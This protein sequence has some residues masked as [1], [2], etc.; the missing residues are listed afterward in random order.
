MV[1]NL[2][3]FEKGE[4]K[5]KFK[6]NL[7]K[8]YFE[9]SDDI[10]DID[11]V[12]S[13]S[14]KKYFKSLQ[15]E[16]QKCY[17]IAELARSKNFD[18]DS[19]VEISIAKN[20]AERVVGLI[21]VVAPQIKGS[22]VV[23]R[24]IELE[25]EYGPLDWRVALKIAEEVAKERFC[26]FKDKK[27]AIEIGIRTGFA[28][29]TV[30]VVSSPLD[31]FIGIDIKQRRDGR[32]EFFCVKYAGPIRNA[33]GTNAALSVLIADYVRKKMGYDVFD[34]DEKEMKRTFT[35]LQDYHERITNLQYNPHEEEIEFLMKHIP[36]EVGG[37]PSEKIEV[38]N[39]KDLPRIETNL[40]RSGF[41]LVMSSCVPL[42]APKLWAKL[43]KWGNDFDMGQWN[44][45]EKYIKLQKELKSKKS[46]KKTSSETST[47]KPKI[48]PDY[49]FV[50]DIVA[51]RP[52]ISHPMQKGGF[53]LRYGRSRTSGYS[54]QSINPATMAVLDNFIAI[55]T[56][57]KVERPGKGAAFTPCE[58][59]E[60]PLVRLKDG[61]VLKLNDYDSAKKYVKEVDKIIFLGDV[62]INYG[63]FFDRAHILVPCG[64]N[65]EW[66]ALEL[67]KAIPEKEL[68]IQSLSART[69][70]KPEIIQDIV[71]NY[72]YSSKYPCI[73]FYNFSKVLDIP[74]H[75]AYTFHFNDV[76][77]DDF[78]KL[79]QWLKFS[80][81]VMKESKYNNYFIDDSILN[82]Q[83]SFKIVLPFKG[84]ENEKLLL[85]NIGVPHEL[86]N[87]EYVVINRDYSLALYAS[88]GLKLVDSESNSK[89]GLYEDKI[90]E[91]DKDYLFEISENLKGNT[92]V[93]DFINSI[94]KIRIRDKS[95]TYIGG[96][97]GRPEKAKMRK[98]QGSPHGLFPVG[99]QGGRMRSLNSA[100]ESGIVKADFSQFY[101][102][103]CKTYTPYRVC[104]KCSKPTNHI[105]LVNNCDVKTIFD[106]VK[107]K[108]N[109]N[110]NKMVKGVRG[111]VN[112]EHI[113][114]F[115]AKSILRA[116]H[117]VHVN[118]DGTVRYD[119][120]EMTCT[121]FK[122]KEI[123]VSIDRL[124]QLGY[125]LDIFGNDLV[126]DN[127][128]LELKPQD[129]ILPSCPDAPEEPADVVLIKITKYIDELLEKVYGI[130]S[131]YNVNKAED[132]VGHLIIGLAPHTSA[133]M[134]GRIIGFSKTQTFLAHPYYHAAERRDTDGDEI[135]FLLLLDG[136]LNFSRKFLT[137]NRGS[138]MDAPLVLSTILRPAEVDDMAFNV[139]VVA[140]YPLEL[141]EAAQQYKAP[142]EI[143]I[144]IIKKLLDSEDQYENMMFTHDTDNFNKGVLCSVYKTLPSMQE[145]LDGQL[146]LARKIRAVDEAD[147]ARLV[148]EKH[149]LKDL[150]GNLRKFSMQKFR[151]VNCNESYRRPPIKGCCLKCNGKIIFTIS[152]G[153]IVKYLQ[154]SLNIADNFAISPYLKQTLELLKLRIEDVFGKEQEKQVGLSTFF[155]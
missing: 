24:I 98:M 76:S 128:V 118:K 13:D 136:F 72:L 78:L 114:E 100:I 64:Y 137:D 155:S 58:T 10:S 63:D 50:S 107:Q 138:T 7:T 131:Y 117:D 73:V 20:M 143:D 99:E 88:L 27:E 97:M 69:N 119:A 92:N 144:K 53:R 142:Y 66:Y 18:P 85:E 147:V 149:F 57:L 62:L 46:A 135:G 133:G 42:K 8:I 108:F 33:G 79:I 16:T 35:E 154:P 141:Y 34:P 106:S 36:V 37:E 74:L 3:Q 71:D 65:E 47:E 43:S 54:A 96:R 129:I 94:S 26:K 109:I 22:G 49:T 146:N 59:I 5:D 150:K 113:P 83:Y 151:C 111:T 89:F 31:G 126:D 130:E 75:P 115:L 87:N 68:S 103:D 91:I 56:Q 52:V 51:G 30:G 112:K 21:S 127:Q 11:V 28:Y 148:I 38:S 120:S 4:D 19:V 77:K 39:Y 12:A 84:Y 29:S 32:G 139:D 70:I 2:N 17:K 134:V 80:E 145:K 105:G 122:P 116:I 9:Y 44:F 124:K 95:G 23:E 152:E 60:G 82:T 123:A 48:L 102:E 41:C 81:I 45:L 86:I 104:L 55:G 6:N 14:I 67:E 25:N 121:H 140:R 125:I 132:L 61:S 101:C 15:N 153:S 93:L 110:T 90:K 1:T 40:I